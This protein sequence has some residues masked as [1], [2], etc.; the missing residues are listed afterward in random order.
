MGILTKQILS[1]IDIE[2][3]KLQNTVYVS[4]YLMDQMYIVHGS[5]GIKK[6]HQ[7]RYNSLMAQ[8]K[9]AKAKLILLGRLL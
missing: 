1:D 7:D 3:S 6:Y 5:A 8:N 9:Q 4:Q 2:K